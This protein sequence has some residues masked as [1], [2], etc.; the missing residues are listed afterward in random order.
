MGAGQATKREETQESGPDPDQTHPPPH[1]LLPLP[2]GKPIHSELKE[3][4]TC[5]RDHGVFMSL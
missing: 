5:G 4:G 2:P 3:A 1:S